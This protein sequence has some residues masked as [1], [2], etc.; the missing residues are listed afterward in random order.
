MGD[1]PR[2]LI[3]G[4]GFAGIEAARALRRAPVAV[5]LVDATN[6]HVFQPLL[7]QVASAAL[8]ASDIAVPIRWLLRRQHNAT[9]LLG[10][11]ADID[12]ERKVVRL[13][14]G[15]ELPYDYLI[16]AAGSRHAYFGHDEWEPCAPGLK[17][18][19]DAAEVRNR[20]LLAFE[21]SER[22]EDPAEREQW[23]TI[24]IVG[25]GPTGVE[26]AGIMASIVRRAIRKDFRRVDTAKTRILLLEGGP[27]LIPAFRERLSRRAEHDLRKLGVD[28][29]LNAIVTKIEPG[30]VWVGEERI[31]TRTIFWAAGNRASPL[32]DRL[33]APLDRA[34]HVNVLPD[35]SVPG[36]PETFVVGDQ[37]NVVQAD[38]SP[39]PRVA[40][41]GMQMGR[42]AARNIL[43][44]LAAAPRR[45]FRY[46][47]HGDLAVI[48]RYRAVAQFPWFSFTGVFA[49]LLWLFV[50]ILYL[51]G[52]RNRL[53]VL[54]EWGYEFVTWQRG[55]RLI[56]E[57]PKRDATAP[58]GGGAS[59]AAPRLQRPETG[60]E[61]PEVEP[62]RVPVR[63]APPRDEN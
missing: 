33:D 40:Q 23:L 54:I 1:R 35:L 2:V 50:H 31:A 39:V 25:G 43:R 12:E 34:G 19:A 38:G 7:Y 5:T 55:S 36:H 3:I 45:E 9:V 29:R 6:H 26:L 28:V 10:T 59:G 61:R 53:S 49:W 11:V 21:R 18:L 56:L 22:A 62:E 41:A 32:S 57:Y 15:A 37:A 27:R 58:S 24:V 51:A 52:F 16:V 63:A 4:G 8:A 48:G 46:Q 47:T 42:T 17:T 30:A 20:F 44:D 14:D 13:E 60:G